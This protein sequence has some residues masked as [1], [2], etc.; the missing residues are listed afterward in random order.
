MSI[1]S[2]SPKFVNRI[3][4]SHYSNFLSMSI[5]DD[6]LELDG[7]LETT[8]FDDDELID[9]PRESDE[10]LHELTGVGV[11]PASDTP[12]TSVLAPCKGS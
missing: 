7:S 1:S 5:I 8:N 3:V 12:I 6:D 2:L 9:I 10:S 4:W 11:A